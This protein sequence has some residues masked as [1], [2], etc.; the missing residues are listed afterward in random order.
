MPQLHQ[1]YPVIEWLQLLRYFTPEQVSLPERVIV[2]APQF[3]T[4]LTNWFINSASRDDGVTTQSLREFFII[5]TILANVGNVD[6]NTREIYRNMNSKIASGTTAP[7][8]RSRVCV[9]AAS[10]TFDQLLGRYFVMKNFG[11]EPQREQV[12]SFISNI[13]STWSQRLDQVDWL[14]AA[15]RTR[16]VDKVSK[17]KHKE[18]YSTLTPDVRSADSLANYYADIA[19]DTL[20]FYANQKSAFQWYIK[21]N[22]NQ[23]GQKVDKSVWHMAPHE[24][25]AYYSPVVNEIVIPA[26]ILQSPFY[27]SELPSYLNYG[28]IGV[29]IG[30]EITVC[31]F[32]I[33]S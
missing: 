12:A 32:T 3:L 29:V 25:N 33:P 28:G 15:T 31:Y 17:I 8:K 4:E 13:Q 2:V 5:K 21:K 18:A 24:V 19:I 27:H 7:P 10:N 22:W 9:G 1:N 20:N 26:G 30:H 11:G 16:A 6:K 14:D 23:L